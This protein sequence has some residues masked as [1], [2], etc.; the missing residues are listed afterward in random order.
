M[1][2]ISYFC[3]SFLNHKIHKGRKD[4][5]AADFGHIRILCIEVDMVNERYL[6][7]KVIFQLYLS[8]LDYITKFNTHKGI[9]YIKMF[10]GLSSHIL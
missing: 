4:E 1:E 7:K 5:L 10:K 8:Q 6:V 3:T 2:M 9:S